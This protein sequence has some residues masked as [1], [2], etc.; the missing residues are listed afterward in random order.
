ML[1]LSPEEI[2]A[3]GQI[4]QFCVFCSFALQTAVLAGRAWCGRKCTCHIEQLISSFS[5]CD[6]DHKEGHRGHCPG[7]HLARSLLDQLQQARAGPSSSSSNGG[8]NSTAAAGPPPGAYVVPPEQRRAPTAATQRQSDGSDGGAAPSEETTSTRHTVRWTYEEF[9][10]ACNELAPFRKHKDMQ[11]EQGN[12]NAERA[13]DETERYNALVWERDMKAAGDANDKEAIKRLNASKPVVQP[14]G[15][16]GRAKKSNDQ[17]IK[18]RTGN[19]VLVEQPNPRDPNGP[20]VY[21][22]QEVQ[23]AKKRQKNNTGAVAATAPT[24]VRILPKDAREVFEILSEYHNAAHEAAYT[25]KGKV[26][27]VYAIKDKFVEY[28][29]KRC[30]YC[31]INRAVELAAKLAGMKPIVAKSAWSRVVIDLKDFSKLPIPIRVPRIPETDEE[32]AAMDRL[33]CEDVEWFDHP[34][35]RYRYVLHVRDHFSRFSILRPLEFKAAWCVAQ[36]LVEIFQVMGVPQVLH[37]DNGSEF[38][39]RVVRSTCKQ[40]QRVTG[41]K[42]VIIT[43]AP[44]RPWHQG[45]V[46]RANRTLGRRV[47]AYCFF[48]GTKDW[49][50]ALGPVQWQMNTSIFTKGHKQTPFKVMF[51]RDPSERFGNLAPASSDRVYNEREVVQGTTLQE[52]MKDAGITVDVGTD[53]DVEAAAARDSWVPTDKQ[54]ILWDK[55]VKDMEEEESKESEQY[56]DSAER[57]LKGGFRRGTIEGM[58]IA[59]M[60]EHEKYKAYVGVLNDRLSAYRNRMI[61]FA[62]KRAGEIAN[63][64][65][66]DLVSISVKDCDPRAL[67]DRFWNSL[68]L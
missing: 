5:S 23:V 3:A 62:R 17:R 51:N 46:E 52:L 11:D 67:D 10:K 61:D 6:C 26:S 48:N 65:V 21:V 29:C 28:F 63:L 43:G 45:S 14:E 16:G 1:G 20:A 30:P 9:I 2:Q 32:A 68:S 19:Y 44:Y 12:P 35:R 40:W 55:Y 34:T 7:G 42:I 64:A 53:E 47:T 57:H 18:N 49:V 37:H 36:A 50:S 25:V 60:K 59:F 33:D 27:R 66:G 24:Q 13:L 4:L 22:M 31:A 41:R 15:C 54:Q 39:N 58:P 38:V 56:L 8:G